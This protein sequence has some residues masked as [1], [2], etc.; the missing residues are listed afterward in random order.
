MARCVARLG[1]IGGGIVIAEGGE[2]R[3]ELPLPVAGLMSD[4]PA[5]EVVARLDELRALLAA[6]AST[7]PRPSWR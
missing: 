6:P 1:E 5:D 4:R 3:G 7:W 2:V